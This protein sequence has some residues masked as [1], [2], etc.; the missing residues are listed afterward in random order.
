MGG[1]LGGLERARTHQSSHDHH[2]ASSF[3]PTMQWIK[4]NKCFY[5]C[6]ACLSILTACC[7]AV[8]ASWLSPGY[9]KARQI[10]FGAAGG[11]EP[12]SATRKDQISSWQLVSSGVAYVPT[13]IN[14]ADFKA[15]VSS[16]ASNEWCDKLILIQIQQ[17]ESLTFYALLLHYL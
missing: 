9:F 15:T 6:L 14:F 11:N 17:E 10:R 12:K 2:P 13:H 3:G 8:F 16:Q 1:C 4:L 7:L 5:F